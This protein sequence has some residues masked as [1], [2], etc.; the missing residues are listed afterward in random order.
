MTEKQKNNTLDTTSN[1]KKLSIQISLNGLSFC[2][3][4]TLDNTVL[5]SKRKVFDTELDPLELEKELVGMFK[6]H[7]VTSESYTE[8]IATHRNTLFCFVPKPL[9]VEEE[10][11]NYLKYNTKVLATD[12][13][14]NDEITN[15]DIVNVFVPLVNINNYIY[16][17]FGDFTYKHSSSIITSSLLNANTNNEITC[18]VYA[19]EK[20][21]D[22]V[23][24]D[25]KKLLLFNSF[26]YLTTEDF[27]YYL[28]FTCEQL[29]LNNETVL[30][31][32][33]GD[34]EEDGT[35]YKNC[36][37]HFKNICVYAP[38]NSTFQLGDYTK[39][40]IDFT[41]LNAL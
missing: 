25:K 19:S 18:Y 8:V 24:I 39:K 31:R 20:Q 21:M 40:N 38:D 17:L 10:A 32:L 2:V 37:N 36:Y 4:D 14:A 30:I 5:L 9:F 3:V 16:D 34:I 26:E 29:K 41:V 22:I 27:L 35:I 15:F 13:I 23:I 6:E 11:H 12:L 33:F 7:N 1:Y 28:L